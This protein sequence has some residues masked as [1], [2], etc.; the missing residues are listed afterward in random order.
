MKTYNTLASIAARNKEKTR[1]INSCA[2]SHAQE[3]RSLCSPVGY[4]LK[5]FFLDPHI[6]LSPAQLAGTVDFRCL[7]AIWRFC[8][9]FL[10]PTAIRDGRRV[11]SAMD[12][13]VRTCDNG[14]LESAYRAVARRTWP[15]PRPGQ[16]RSGV[17]TVSRRGRRHMLAGE[18]LYHSERWVMGSVAWKTKRALTRASR[19]CRKK[20]SRAY[21]V[22]NDN[23][24]MRTC[25]QWAFTPSSYNLA[26]FLD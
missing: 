2:R 10:G 6:S 23:D 20:I 9:A 19:A 15:L 22:I 8:I 24:F 16:D 18:H 26:A 11:S 14:L 5:G 4:N 12:E 25:P 7:G 3:Q 21:I 13:Y 1:A 17:M